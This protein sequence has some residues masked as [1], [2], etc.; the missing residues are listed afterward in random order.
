[1][2]VWTRR[3]GT[4]LGMTYLLAAPLAAHIA[5]V[6]RHGTDL[7]GLLI[8]AQAALV[9]WVALSLTV[10]PSI[11]RRPA[12]W[13]G[14]RVAVSVALFGL[15]AVLWRRSGDGMMLTAAVPHAI[16]YLGLLTLFAASLAPGREAIITIVARRARGALSDELLHYTRCVTIAWCCFFAAQLA[17]SLLLWLLAPLVWWSVFVNLCTVPLVALMFG[18]ELAYRH[19]RHGVHLPTAQTGRLR[20]ALQV[21]GQ[22]RL[23]VRQVE[24]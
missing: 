12:R 2:R 20:Q 3:L 1:M 18:A 15:A 14:I 5:I 10:S 21:A 24:P 4:F 7:A 23:P 11:R 6:T 13:R 8:A 22:M 16:A 9:G 19:W 17:T